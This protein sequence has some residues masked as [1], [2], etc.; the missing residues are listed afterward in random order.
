VLLL[1]VLPVALLPVAWAGALALAAAAAGLLSA[2]FHVGAMSAKSR[3]LLR[4]ACDACRYGAPAVIPAVSYVLARRRCLPR[5][6]ASA[7]ALALSVVASVLF[8]R[9]FTDGGGAT[10]RLVAGVSPMPDVIGFVSPLFSLLLMGAWHR[11][12]AAQLSRGGISG[13]L[14]REEG[15]HGASG[16]SHAVAVPGRRGA[17]LHEQPRQHL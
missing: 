12:H 9:V 17:G 1:I 5:A 7:P 14:F 16:A 13:N 4:I 10:G 6:W 2:S 3:G 15:H 8:V 11:A